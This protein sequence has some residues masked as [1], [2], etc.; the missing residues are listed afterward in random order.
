MF[1]FTDEKPKGQGAFDLREFYFE[2]DFQLPTLTDVANLSNEDFTPSQTHYNMC[3]DMYK[4]MPQKELEN[5]MQSVAP[6]NVQEHKLTNKSS[7]LKAASTLA[8]LTSV[9]KVKYLCWVPE[10]SA[11][12]EQLENWDNTLRGKYVCKYR[13]QQSDGTYNLLE[14]TVGTDWVEKN[15]SVVALSYIQRLGNQVSQSLPY[16]DETGNQHSMKGFVD[17]EAENVTVEMET[18]LFNRF[19]YVPSQESSDPTIEGPVQEK[20]IAYYND[21]KETKEVPYDYLEGILDKKIL[22][23][24]KHA[25]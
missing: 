1:Q 18:V 14:I 5:M 23:T 21:L 9:E 20:W 15:F 8:A 2:D 10:L 13:K 24:T 7:K 22:E 19:R 17:I 3:L 4:N 6:E 16:Q 11:E 12:G 25:V